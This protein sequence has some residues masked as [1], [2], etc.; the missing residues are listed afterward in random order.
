M[1][2]L[3]VAVVLIGYSALARVVRASSGCRKDVHVNVHRS[4]FERACW[5]CAAI[6]RGFKGARC[7]LYCFERC[8]SGRSASASVGSSGYLGLSDC[9]IPSVRNCLACSYSMW[10]PMRHPGEHGGLELQPCPV[11]RGRFVLRSCGNL[12]VFPVCMWLLWS[13]IEGPVNYLAAVKHVGLWLWLHF[14]HVA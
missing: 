3:C 1:R 5:G 8:K 11:K 9:S 13:M 4:A 12:Q 7:M 14:A 2:A 10:K 6:H